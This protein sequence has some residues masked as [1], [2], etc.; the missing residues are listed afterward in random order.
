ML[1]ITK[2]QRFKKSTLAI[3]KFQKN[4]TVVNCKPVQIYIRV[5]VVVVAKGLKYHVDILLP[6]RKKAFTKDHHRHPKLQGD[7]DKIGQEVGLGYS[8]RS[9][10]LVSDLTPIL[11]TVLTPVL[12]HQLDNTSCIFPTSG[13]TTM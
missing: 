1:L 8:H 13:Y 3:K 5:L 6:A 12:R 11:P 7:V 4:I 10:S 9:W 2:Q